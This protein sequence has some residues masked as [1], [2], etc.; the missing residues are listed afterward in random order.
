[1]PAAL[2]VTFGTSNRTIQVAHFRVTEARYAP[3]LTVPRHEHCFPS[4]T[5]LLDGSFEE[6]YSRR[7]VSAR[8]GSI[9]CKAA[10]AAHSNRYGTGGARVLVVELTRGETPFGFDARDM[11]EDVRLY[12]SA[13]A[14]RT[15]RRLTTELHRQEP[16][17]PLGVE[18]ALLDVAL[19]F[20]RKSPAAREPREA[21]IDRVT[22]RLTLEFVSPPPLDEMARD[23]GVHPVHLC[24]GFRARH[25]CSPGT[26]VRR[27]RL[28][29]AQRQL[30]GTDLSITEIGLNA[31][32]SDHSHLCR[33]F[34]KAF[35]LS[36]SLYRRQHRR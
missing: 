30:A 15:I 8:P 12:Q 17:W 18:A 19:L 21:W 20:M 7:S 1:M 11:F 23:A 36:P 29:H 14:V 5:L 10:E 9:L 35:G 2:P 34:R 13:V 24:A 28:A 31:G 3:G 33:S 25:G 26:F 32:F 6:H 16:G 27:L 22:E 4:W